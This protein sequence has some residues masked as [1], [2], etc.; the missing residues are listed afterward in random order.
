M[1]K[2]T[3]ATEPL[4]HRSEWECSLMPIIIGTFFSNETGSE[5][6]N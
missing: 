3:M 1:Y 5:I 2:T 4:G 6:K